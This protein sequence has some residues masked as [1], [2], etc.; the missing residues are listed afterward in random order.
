MLLIECYRKFESLHAD[1]KLTL[2]QFWK[3]VADELMFT[4][5]EIFIE[6][7]KVVTKKCTLQ[8][9]FLKK[10]YKDVLKANKKSGNARAC[11]EYFEVCFN[12]LLYFCIKLYFIVNIKHHFSST[13]YA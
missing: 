3:K 10:K 6:D 11:W 8:M 7:R 5:P 9:T 13:E 1:G 4:N 12:R 2:D